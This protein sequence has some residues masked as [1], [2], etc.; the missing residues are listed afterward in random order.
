MAF[1]KNFECRGCGS[2]LGKSSTLPNGLKTTWCF[3][4]CAGDFMLKANEMEELEPEQV[5]NLMG[6]EWGTAR[7]IHKRLNTPGSK[8]AFRPSA[9]HAKWQLYE[10]RNNYVPPSEIH[11]CTKGT[12][13]GLHTPSGLSEQKN[14]GGCK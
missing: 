12:K 5:A 2:R 10:R 4:C 1:L 3:T 8:S 9:D 7:T 6:R 13:E 14:R 11:K